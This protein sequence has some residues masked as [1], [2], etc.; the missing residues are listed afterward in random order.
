[1]KCGTTC[2]FSSCS[3]AEIYDNEG[4]LKKNPYSIGGNYREIFPLA[5]YDWQSVPSIKETV[6]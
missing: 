4:E 3:E 5:A 6:K 1:M 2:L